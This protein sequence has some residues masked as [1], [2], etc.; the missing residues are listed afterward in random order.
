[1]IMN[2]LSLH[3]IY[4]IIAGLIFLTVT[5]AAILIHT[6]SSRPN[7]TILDIQQKLGFLEVLW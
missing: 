3:I 5:L 2:F 4:I 7:Q 6:L 1:M